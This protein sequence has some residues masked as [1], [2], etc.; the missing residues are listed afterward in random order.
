MPLHLTDLLVECKHIGATA[1]CGEPSTNKKKSLRKHTAGNTHSTKMEW[2]SG[3]Y[4]LCRVGGLPFPSNG[5]AAVYSSDTSALM[6]ANRAP[7]RLGDHQHQKKRNMCSSCS[8]GLFMQGSRKQCHTC[9]KMNS[10]C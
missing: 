10:P 9:V 7:L 8:P 3:G 4:G 5:P 2:T 6:S 1:R